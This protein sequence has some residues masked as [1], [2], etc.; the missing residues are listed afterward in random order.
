MSVPIC[1]CLNEI[2]K[3]SGRF[4]NNREI[5]RVIEYVY[6]MTIGNW[7]HGLKILHFYVIL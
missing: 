6:S 5:D 3:K 1:V 7:L 2:F 4:N